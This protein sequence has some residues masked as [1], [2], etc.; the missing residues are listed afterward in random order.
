VK[1]ASLAIGLCV[2]TMTY[3][4]VKRELSFDRG[5]PD[6]ERIL[7]LTVVQ[8]GLPGAP[9]GSFNTV[10]ARAWPAL[11]DYFSDQIAQATRLAN[12]VVR[13]GESDDARI[14]NLGYVDPAF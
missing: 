14:L 3:L 2:F 8:Q 11:L 1:V 9:D 5:W 6:A 10:N 4:Y 13:A 7:R 12:V